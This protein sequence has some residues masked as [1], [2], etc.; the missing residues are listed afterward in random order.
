M[1]TV[2][3]KSNCPECEKAYALLDKAGLSYHKIKVDED[4]AART[5]LI[6]EGHKAVPQIYLNDE[7][8]GNYK[9]L[10]SLGA[11][12]LDNLYK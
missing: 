8:I 7:Y 1:L 10:L 11:E 6:E 12:G 2:Y 9:K 4:T 3:S 5:F